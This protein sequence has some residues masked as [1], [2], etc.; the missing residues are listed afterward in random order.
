LRRFTFLLLAVLSL[1]P[2][3]SLAQQPA[4]IV[5]EIEATGAT[6]SQFDYVVPGRVID[7]GAEGTL[8]L[9]YLA[10]CERER[11]RGG[12]VTVGQ[13]QS[14]VVGGSVKR[15]KIVCDGGLLQLSSDQSQ[16]SLT[17][18]FRDFDAN[19]DKNLPNPQSRLYSV[20]PVVSVGAAGATLTI[21]RIDRT[22]QPVSLVLNAATVDLAT[23][24][25]GLSPGGL[26]QARAL[27]RG[28]TFKIDPSAGSGG[29]IV[30]RLLRF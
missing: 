13:E 11:I 23:Q 15:L 10:S 5:E 29:P 20:S 7:L 22:E 30:G 1:L 2:G 25:I 3:V 19:K 12:K 16:Q 14:T 17:V 27:G 9:G 6:L 8:T 26:Y 18:V 4:A 24:G 21:Q 28:I